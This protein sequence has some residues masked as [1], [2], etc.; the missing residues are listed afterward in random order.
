MKDR[1]SPIYDCVSGSFCVISKSKE[2][3][4]LE[5]FAETVGTLFV[6]IH[7]EKSHI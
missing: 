3:K 2:F 7:F 4:S 1:N 5:I 6:A